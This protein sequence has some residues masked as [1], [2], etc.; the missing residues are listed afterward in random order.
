MC[1]KFQKVTLIGRPCV[2]VRAHTLHV[3]IHKHTYGM[4][5][6]TKSLASGTPTISKPRL[7]SRG[8]SAQSRAH[9]TVCFY[10]GSGGGASIL[11][12][13]LIARLGVGC[14]PVTSK[15][16]DL[17]CGPSVAVAGGWAEVT[18]GL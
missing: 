18:L 17:R 16:L 6:P 12:D 11:A 9:R 13:P 10:N 2:S 15:V 14:T 4:S 5:D 1:S 3:C 8:E 7:M